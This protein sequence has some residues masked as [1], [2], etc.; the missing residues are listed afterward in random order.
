MEHTEYNCGTCMFY[1]RNKDSH[2]E[3]GDCIRFPPHVFPHPEVQ[4]I[5]QKVIMKRMMMR[6]GVR[7]DEIC[8]EYQPLPDTNNIN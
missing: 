1:A 3:T 7:E 8:G 2:G 6:P 4:Q 5:S